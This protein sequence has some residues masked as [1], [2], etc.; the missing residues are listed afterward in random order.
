MNHDKLLYDIA[1]TQLF[2]VGPRTARTLIEH[3]GS[4]EAIFKENPEILRQIGNVGAYISDSGYQ[5]E[6]L[7][8]LRQ[9]RR[10]LPHEGYGHEA[11]G[12]RCKMHRL[13]HL[14]KGLPHG[15]PGDRR[16]VIS[17]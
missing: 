6:A 4:A 16:K 10:G 7:R 9:V 11:R 14:C 17:T 1:L 15:D 3:F 2:M 8:Q 12:S 5:Q 13:R